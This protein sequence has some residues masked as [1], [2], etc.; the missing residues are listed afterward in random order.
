M[1]FFKRLWKNIVCAEHKSGRTKRNERFRRTV[2]GKQIKKH[3]KNIDM[4]PTEAIR[5]KG[6]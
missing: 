3:F 1:G 6:K 2:E 4:R 5:E